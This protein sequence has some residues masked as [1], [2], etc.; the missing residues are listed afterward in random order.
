M[1]IRSTM[2]ELLA[3]GCIISAA[4]PRCVAAVSDEDFS[5]VKDAVQKLT[6]Q[7][8]DLLKLHQQDQKT[9]EEDQQKIQNL[10][11]Q[12]GE[13]QKTAT[14]AQQKA[15]SAAQDQQKI[16]NLQQ[17]LTQTQKTASD[18]QQKAEAAS[19]KV[20]S[21]SP[22]LNSAL[23]SATRNFALVG[24]AEVQFGKMQG[25]GQNGTPGTAG[26]GTHPTFFMA[27]FA[28]IFLYRAND[29]VLFE[30]GFDTT[31]QNN[32]NTVHD[33]GSGSSFSLSFAT[34]DYLFNDYL[35]FVA[36]DMLLPL[37]TYS[38]RTAG[39]LNKIPDDPLAR[40]VLPGN[41][42]GVQL[43]GALPIGQNGQS[44]SYA[45]FVAN[46]PSST[47]TTA[48]AG[49][50]DL[51]GNTGTQS[52]NSGLPSNLHDSPSVGGRFAWFFPWKPHYD[53]ELGLSGQA[54]QWD[55]A[56]N[57]QWSAGVVDA[58]VHLSPYFEAKGEFI[59]TWVESDDFGTYQPR[60]WWVQ[61]GYKLA[62]LNLELPM[63]NNV[64]LV[65]RYDRV[66]NGLEVAGM[67]A[68]TDRYTG[69]FVYYITNTLQF[70]GD[71]EVF[72]GNDP[73]QPKS[74]IVFQLSFGF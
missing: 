12:V 1:K 34:V 28:P 29:N 63:I 46:G 56:G 59:N 33:A 39:F 8:Q 22:A 7:M 74:E 73:T 4:L 6:Q 72:R 30:A 43:R 27:D 47:N 65:A 2:F 67:G 42:V 68:K 36:G 17:Q 35:T 23:A 31:L 21:A 26:A 52:I 45:A 44:F 60:G 24:D 15:E 14:A 58:A 5:A 25:K 32:N 70:E 51:G 13:T 61:A 11:K 66:D 10:Q 40:N 53:V 55:D 20:Q 41:G 18:A 3:A 64:E 49:S 50:L 37:G 48:T 19:N 69:G 9:H 54:G 16:Q 71:Y 57:R 62:G 38:E